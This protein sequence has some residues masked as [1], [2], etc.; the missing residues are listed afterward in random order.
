MQAGKVGLRVGGVGHPVLAVQ[1]VG[2]R[3]VG[4][5]CFMLAVIV[6][7]PIPFGNMLQSLAIAAFGIGAV[8]RD[9]IAV[10]AGWIVAVASVA[11]LALLSKAIIAAHSSSPPSASG[12]RACSC[13][14]ASRSGTR[15]A[16][17]CSTTSAVDFPMPGT[18]WM[19]P[20]VSEMTSR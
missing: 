7:L 17:A 18:D 5:A 1:E 6:F 3:L 12:V 14:A 4:A 10:I 8:E 13:R 20:A 11:V 9:G 2:D 19:V 16:C 15:P